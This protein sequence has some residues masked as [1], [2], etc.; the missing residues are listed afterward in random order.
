M[1]VM[2]GPRES[3]TSYFLPFLPFVRFLLNFLGIQ[4][5]PQL[6]ALGNCQGLLFRFTKTLGSVAPLDL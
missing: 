3:L 6:R 1:A 5:L 2:A 4:A